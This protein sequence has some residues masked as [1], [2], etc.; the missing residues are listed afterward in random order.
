MS[1]CT[2]ALFPQVGSSRSALLSEVLLQRIVPRH[3]L[4]ALDCDSD[5]SS[6]RL[7]V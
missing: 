5:H 3:L 2:T 7:A 6:F 4:M 1:L